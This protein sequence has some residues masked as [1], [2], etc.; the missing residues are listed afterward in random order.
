METYKI[1]RKYRDNK[2][3]DHNKVIKTGLTLEEAQAHCQ[4]P[5]TQEPGVWFDCYYQEDRR[6]N[7]GPSLTKA[8]YG[9]YP[10]L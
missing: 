2:H 10:K 8:L 4:D 9:I 5:S 6:E 3:P 1:V 7:P